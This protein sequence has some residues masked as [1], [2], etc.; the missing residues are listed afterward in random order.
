MD[1]FL[2]SLVSVEKIKKD[3]IESTLIHNLQNTDYDKKNE[4][5]KNDYKT[6][7]E[8]NDSSTTFNNWDLV[9]GFNTDDY[10]YRNSA[11]S[12]LDEHGSSIC[13]LVFDD[14]EQHFVD[15]WFKNSNSFLSKDEQL[16]FDFVSEETCNLYINEKPLQPKNLGLLKNIKTENTIFQSDNTNDCNKIDIKQEY[17]NI[18]DSKNI[19]T[20]DLD[21]K[22]KCEFD[23]NYKTPITLDYNFNSTIQE[24]EVDFISNNRLMTVCAFNS[25][26]FVSSA[27]K[28]FSNPTKKDEKPNIEGKNNFEIIEKVFDFDE[29]VNFEQYSKNIDESLHKCK[30]E[31][32]NIFDKNSNNSDE[33]MNNFKNSSNNPYENHDSLKCSRKRQSPMNQHSLEEPIIK[34]NNINDISCFSFDNFNT[35]AL[36][37]VSKNDIDNSHGNKIQN[38][39]EDQF[40][41]K[42]LNL[43]I[44]QTKEPQSSSIGFLDDL[45]DESQSI[46]PSINLGT[47][48][49]FYDTSDKS[50]LIKAEMNSVENIK[51]EKKL[52]RHSFSTETKNCNSYLNAKRNSL[53]FKPK[54]INEDNIDIFSTNFKSVQF[55]NFSN[56]TNLNNS[57]NQINRI[58][59]SLQ[60]YYQRNVFDPNNPSYEA[61]TTNQREPLL[62]N[63][64]CLPNILNSGSLSK[65][66]DDVFKNGKKI[67]S[68]PISSSF[69]APNVTSKIPV[70]SFKNI[71]INILNTSTFNGSNNLESPPSF[72]NTSLSRLQA[73]LLINDNNVKVTSI[74]PIQGH[75]SDIQVNSP[76]RMSSKSEQFL[77]QLHFDSQLKNNSNFIEFLNNLEKL[78][79]QLKLSSLAT[80]KQQSYNQIS[81]NSLQNQQNHQQKSTEITNNI[82]SFFPLLL[83]TPVQSVSSTQLIDN[84]TQTFQNINS[85]AQKSS[86]SH[87]TKKLSIYTCSFNGCNRVYKSL[88]HLRAH[89]KQHSGVKPYQCSW[90]GCE[91]SFSR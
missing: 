10:S 5:L 65:L 43:L 54:I 44:S 46:Q 59:N 55:N 63:N 66:S 67:T 36:N 16:M 11:S 9:D 28:H 85:Q 12:Q 18:T 22:I 38:E 50:A 69:F 64:S 91:W 45:F 27:N 76:N 15:Y 19:S 80:R 53:D 89:I 20:T 88:C 2:A 24:S 47:S 26:C 60:K 90:S 49:N 42:L 41:E 51:S 3:L 34:S 33:K 62:D 75:N 40:S 30:N 39:T 61:N 68:N 58:D 87:K 72:A 52:L 13:D 23:K 57:F 71:P 21:K 73:P 35:D 48:T 17:T 8:T 31:K 29:N 82:L 79:Q 4:G 78:H 14:E 32:L 37:D 77:K 70:N 74:Q 86:H 6:N 1:P 83:N 56:P 84:K 81:Q 7:I 25:N